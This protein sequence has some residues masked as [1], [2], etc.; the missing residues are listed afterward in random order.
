MDSYDAPSPVGDTSD[1]EVED[2]DEDEEAVGTAGKRKR[3]EEVE[4]EENDDDAL[5]RPLCVSWL[6]SPAPTG[7]FW[8]PPLTRLALD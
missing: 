6:C 3:V 7:F 8:K 2:E 4:E 5:A 1:V